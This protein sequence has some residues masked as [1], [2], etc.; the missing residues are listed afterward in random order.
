MTIEL[1][2]RKGVEFLHAVE[3]VNIVLAGGLPTAAMALDHV[4]AEYE[5]ALAILYPLDI[6]DDYSR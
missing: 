5:N 4:M 3:T 1:D 2:L 6:D